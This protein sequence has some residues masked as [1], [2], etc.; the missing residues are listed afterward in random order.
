MTDYPSITAA[1]TLFTVSIKPCELTSFEAS[2]LTAYTF[3]TNDATTV[4]PYVATVPN[5]YSDPATC[6]SYTTTY[7]A[8]LAD[9][10][11]TLT[12]TTTSS[13]TTEATSTVVATTTAAKTTAV[14]D[15]PY[16]ATFDSTAK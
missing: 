2:S 12:V 11:S 16:W 3:T 6:T 5:F 14:S 8:Y 15:L 9:A 10:A 1:E 4:Y 7:K 13:I